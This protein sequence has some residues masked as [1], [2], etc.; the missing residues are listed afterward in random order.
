[1]KKEGKNFEGAR[2]SIAKARNLRKPMTIQE[3]RLWDYLRDHRLHGM[4]FRRQQPLDHYI[5]DFCCLERKFVVELDGAVHDS[6]EQ[7][8]YDQ[9][10]DQYLQN[11]GFKVLRITNSEIDREIR[12]VLEKIGKEFNNPSPLAGEGSENNENS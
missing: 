1:M 4:K 12:S 6:E 3:S 8:K 2:L 5:A 11:Q 7:R 9:E 10:R